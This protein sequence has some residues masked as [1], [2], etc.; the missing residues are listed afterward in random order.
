M[1]KLLTILAVAVAMAACN[2]SGESSVDSAAKP[3]DT[4][5]SATDSGM[6]KMDSMPTDSSKMKMSADTA[7]KAK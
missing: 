3:A 6:K 1:K 2:N 4:I 5:K 7:S